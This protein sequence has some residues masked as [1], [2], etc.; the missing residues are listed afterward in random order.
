M[1]SDTWR[2]FDKDMLMTNG[3]GKGSW[4]NKPTV[5]FP[6]EGLSLGSPAGRGRVDMVSQRKTQQGG[7]MVGCGRDAMV[8]EPR[9][10]Q[11]FQRITGLGVELSCTPWC[12][13]CKLLY[14]GPV[15]AIT[16]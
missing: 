4:G 7:A 13:S 1:E 15:T 6:M 14:S 11:Y 12:S 8:G 3:L 9:V 2:A 16:K 10:E 5:T